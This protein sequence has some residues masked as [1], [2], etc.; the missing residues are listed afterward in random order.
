MI[1][2]QEH[3]II[4][5]PILVTLD[6]LHQNPRLDTVEFRQVAIEH[7]PLLTKHQNTTANQ[8]LH[9]NACLTHTH[10]RPS[11]HILST[12]TMAYIRLFQS[13]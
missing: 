11:R 7:Y 2:K 13:N 8:R 5:K 6:R 3:E 9:W 10:F 12:N 1:I 4:R